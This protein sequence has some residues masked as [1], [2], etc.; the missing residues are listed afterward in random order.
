MFFCDKPVSKNNA[1]KKMVESGII[2]EARAA[3]MMASHGEVA[4]I[5]G[6]S[7]TTG[8]HFGDVW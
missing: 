7:D 2:P 1:L 5:I 6:G 8:R 4:Y 3:C